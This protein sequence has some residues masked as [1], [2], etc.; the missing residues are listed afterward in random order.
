MSNTPARR[1]GSARQ[2]RAA[3][4]AVHL[5]LG[6]IMGFVIYSP[7]V[8]DELLRAVFAFGVFPALTVTGMLLWQQAK[9]RRL[10]RRAP[11][12]VP[13]TASVDPADGAA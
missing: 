9:V 11:V 12:R 2:T 13:V 10:L 5:A 6:T 3:L 1:R 4:R 7:T 8:S